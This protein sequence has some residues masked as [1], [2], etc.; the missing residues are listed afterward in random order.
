M[1]HTL[2]GYVALYRI[3]SSKL[4]ASLAIAD[5]V[6]DEIKNKRPLKSKY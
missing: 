4:N 6:T 1:N 2:R 3:E 5:Y